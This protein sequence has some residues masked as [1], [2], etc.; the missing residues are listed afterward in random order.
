MEENEELSRYNGD[1]QNN[2]EAL[3]K[4]KSKAQSNVLIFGII[5]AFFLYAGIKILI[6]ISALESTYSSS[7]PES[8]IRFIFKSELMYG[9]FSVIGKWGCFGFFLILSILVYWVK[10]KGNLKTI[11]ECNALIGQ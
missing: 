7:V 9:I 4:I 10:I 3:Q 11:K 6:D 8:E 5:I 2:R 1:S